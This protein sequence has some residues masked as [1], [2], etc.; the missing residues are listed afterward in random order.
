MTND[1]GAEHEKLA[2]EIVD[3]CEVYWAG[4]VDCEKPIDVAL[5]IIALAHA[6]GR[7][8]AIAEVLPVLEKISTFEKWCGKLNCTCRQDM[9]R[10]LLERLTPTLVNHA[11]LTKKE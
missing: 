3:H 11:E 7:R 6:A 8:Q 5:R 10:A 1:K 9:A 4:Y 2:G